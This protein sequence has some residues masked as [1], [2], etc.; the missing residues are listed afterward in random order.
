[1]PFTAVHLPIKEPEEYLQRVP[2]EIQGEVPRQYA[3]CVMHLDDAVGRIVAALEKSGK[4]NNTLLIFTS[5]NG[6]STAE[7][8]GQQYPK[9][10]YPVG[11]LP[12]NNSPL[13]GQKGDLYEGGIRV[14][15][16][17]SWPGKL[18]A[19]KCT[20]TLQITDWMPTLCAL[21]GH[22]PKR[23][24]K[25]DGTNIWPVLTGTATRESHLL[26]WTAPGFRARAVRAGEVLRGEETG[27]SGW[28]MEGVGR[29]RLWRRR[30]GD[31]QIR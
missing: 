9:D 5:D 31:R 20:A 29:E 24:L 4:R 3:A 13:R 30:T 6:G 23:D 22:T 12:G 11:K 27:E 10:D 15:A 1:M 25:W 26:Y 7:N 8:A 14:P 19:G 28:L 2:A 18:T 21:A 16:I 17:A